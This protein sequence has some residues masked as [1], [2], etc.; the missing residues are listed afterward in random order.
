MK[1]ADKI[2]TLRKKQGW[3]QEELADR[4]AVTRQSVSKWEGDQ[5]VPELEKI[6]AMADLFDVSTDFLLREES[7]EENAAENWGETVKAA[8]EDEVAVMREVTEDEIQSYL[9][10][11]RRGAVGTAVAVALCVL[12]PATLIFLAGLSD[13]RR[14]LSEGIAAGIG[15]LVL[16]GMIAAAVALFIVGASRLEGFAYLEKDGFRMEPEARSFVDEYWKKHAERCVALRVIATVLCVLSVTPLFVALFFS[17]QS[18]AAL[19]AVPLLLMMVSAGVFLF[20]LSGEL[21]G[22]AEALIKRDGHQPENAGWAKLKET[23]G[24]VYWLGA[25]AIYLGYSFITGDWDESW[26]IWPIAGIL[27]AILAVVMEHFDKKKQ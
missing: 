18:Y 1:L 21:W 11:K 3:S 9:G 26:I 14:L 16:M 17:E 8:P 27:F 23:V 22:C 4:L 19:V 20:V 25:V 6:V 24:S 10:K 12:S 2:I 7:T 5:S 15:L 13:E